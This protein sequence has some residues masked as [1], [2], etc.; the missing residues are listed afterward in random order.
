VTLVALIVTF[1]GSNSE[2][3]S[4]VLPNDHPAEQVQDA[5]LRTQ[6]RRSSSSM[7]TPSM[8]RCHRDGNPSSPRPVHGCASGA[9]TR[10]GRGSVPTLF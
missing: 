10:L 4:I 7:S 3:V 2:R 1:I 6:D 9:K 5:L 8:S